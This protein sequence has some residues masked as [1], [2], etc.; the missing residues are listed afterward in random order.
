M[1]AIRATFQTRY[2][3]AVISR[4]AVARG[5]NGA[6]VAGEL[7]DQLAGPDVRLVVAFADA[8]VDDIAAFA[9]EL[10]RRIDAPVIGCTANAVVGFAETAQPT[11]TAMALCGDWLRVGIGVASEL[12]K[13]PIVRSRDAVRR[14]A[15]ALRLEPDA[16]DPVRHVAFTLI[17]GTSRREDSF[18]IG[19]A[20]AMP[21]IKVVGG[22]ASSDNDGHCDARVFA[23]G[24]P[25]A[26]AGIIT[27]LETKRRWEA[28]TSQHV[29]PTELKVVVTAVGGDREIV[30]LDGK[31]AARRLH[32]LLESIGIELGAP[33]PT[34]F[35]FARYVDGVPYVRIIRAIEGSAIH[36]ATSVEPGHVMHVMRTGDLV[37][38]TRAD[39]AAVDKRIGGISALLAW[40]CMAR[41]REAE[42]SGLVEPLARVYAERQICGFRSFG[43]QSGMLLVSYTLAGLAFGAPL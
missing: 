17:D 12:S 25:M 38:T 8:Q 23:F 33:R 43:E 26:D 28:F 40:S 27:V 20:A 10:Q 7:A 29:V 37:G 31:P 39:L 36:V 9:R 2:S 6:A 22:V 11:S 1:A 18:C 3:R 16:L 32:E 5:A 42:A 30:E 15:A 34:R 4:I 21:Q 13:S 24:E 41:H 35:T 14:A 19:S